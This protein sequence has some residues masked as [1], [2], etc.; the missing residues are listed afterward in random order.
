M[1]SV[2]APCKSSALE[3]P[4]HKDI[5]KAKTLDCTKS[6]NI[7]V[8]S[9]AKFSISIQGQQ[10]LVTIKTDSLTVQTTKSI[11]NQSKDSNTI[12]INGEGNS[13]SINQETKGNVAIKQSGN[14][15]HI[16]ISQSSHQP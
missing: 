11:A 14:N 6:S 12:E 16:N 13:V 4:K 15:N 1:F 5:L 9:I 3:L 2:S 8:D 10:N 7:K